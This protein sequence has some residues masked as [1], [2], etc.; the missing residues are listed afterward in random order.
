ME[1]PQMDFVHASEYGITVVNST[2]DNGVHKSDDG[3]GRQYSI[4]LIERNCLRQ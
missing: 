1:L 2:D 4:R 3:V